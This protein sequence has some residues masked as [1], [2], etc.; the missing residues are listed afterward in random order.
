MVDP[1]EVPLRDRKAMNAR[2]LA[3]AA[4]TIY[5]GVDLPADKLGMEG[6]DTFV[7]S[8]GDT[9][10]QYN[11]GKNIDTH[12]DYCVTILNYV[13]PNAHGRAAHCWSSAN[14]TPTTPLPG[15]LRRTTSRSRTR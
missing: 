2:K 6:Y 5:L 9:L 8:T 15:S 12:V 3:Q 14:S 11:N 4:F 10:A 7:R 13:I 1:A